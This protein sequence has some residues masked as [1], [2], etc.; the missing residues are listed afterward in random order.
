MEKEM[1]EE[2][3]TPEVFEHLVDLAAIALDPSQSDYLR[4]ELNKQLKAINELIAIPIDESVP[5]AAHGVPYMQAD[6][7]PLRED[8]WEACENPEEILAQVPVSE[9][10]YI[11]VPDIPHSD[12]E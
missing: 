8:C 7:A 3:I 4:G 5:L 1:S 12:L 11:V 9:D 6:A 10:G 2:F